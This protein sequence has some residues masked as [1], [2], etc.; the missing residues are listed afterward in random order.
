[1]TETL[2][3]GYSSESTQRGLSNEYQH[4]KVSMV[5]KNLCVRM[6]WMKVVSALVGLV[7]DK[8][9]LCATRVVLDGAFLYLI[10][11]RVTCLTERFSDF[12]LTR[13]HYIWM[14][15]PRGE[16]HYVERNVAKLEAWHG[17]I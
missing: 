10:S 2:A 15:L 7:A 1:M 12:R 5:Y 4:E 16:F 9:K 8:L 6:L 17:E 13:C 3:Y 14:N 11:G